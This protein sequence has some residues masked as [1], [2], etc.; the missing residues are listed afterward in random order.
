VGW[1]HCG[2]FLGVG[3]RFFGACEAPASVFPAWA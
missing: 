3:D 1:V 2:A